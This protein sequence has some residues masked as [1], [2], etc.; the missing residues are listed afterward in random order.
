MDTIPNQQG[1]N[2][3]CVYVAI[4]YKS[5]SVAQVLTTFSNKGEQQSTP[6]WNPRSGVGARAGPSSAPTQQ[7]ALSSAP[8]L[9]Q[10]GS[11]YFGS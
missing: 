7:E 10:Y 8:P 6:L 3:I 5:S 9:N 11:T 4:G 2:V 1:Q